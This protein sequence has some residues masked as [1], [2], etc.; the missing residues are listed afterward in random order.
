M[1]KIEPKGAQAPAGSMDEEGKQGETP[2]KRKPGEY[3]RYRKE[4]KEQILKEVMEEL[5]PKEE[6]L[7]MTEYVTVT[8]SEPKGN[9]CVEFLK[10]LGCHDVSVHEAV[11][12][13]SPQQLI[14]A[15]K[16]LTPGED[17]D[18]LRVN[19]RDVSQ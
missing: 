17:P 12:N 13:G 2:N 16:N 1:A 8:G 5:F 6:E 19:K 15:L 18:P 9:F 11:L 10:F 4:L 3:S 14:V 7:D